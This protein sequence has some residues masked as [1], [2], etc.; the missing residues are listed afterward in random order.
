MTE[1]E[2]NPPLTSVISVQWNTL[3]LRQNLAFTLSTTHRSEFS[4]KAGE[5]ELT[6]I[7]SVRIA[8]LGILTNDMP[9]RSNVRY[10]KKA[11]TLIRP[12]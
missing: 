3:Y 4:P 8:L 7:R 9:H 1:R 12:L 2:E 5:C 11:G 10:K 6:L